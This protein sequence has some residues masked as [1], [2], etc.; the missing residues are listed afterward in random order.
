MECACC[1]GR[2]NS[3]ATIEE[4]GA[5]QMQ[6]IELWID[7]VRNLSRRLRWQKK[8]AI[9]ILLHICLCRFGVLWCRG[10]WVYARS[11]LKGGI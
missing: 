5:M 10:P 1:L 7:R 9:S 8:K 3:T 2:Y 4:M 11:Q 6:E